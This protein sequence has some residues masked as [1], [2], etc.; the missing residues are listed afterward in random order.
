MME[1]KPTAGSRSGTAMRL[2]HGATWILV[3][4]M[5]RIGSVSGKVRAKQGVEILTLEKAPWCM[6]PAKK[7]DQ[8]SVHYIGKLKNGTV[9]DEGTE[10]VGRPLGFTL[11]QDAASSLTGN[12]IEG[13]HVGLEGMCLHEKRRIVVPPSLAYGDEGMPPSIPGKATLVFDVEL[14]LLNGQ[15]M[16]PLGE[17]EYCDGCLLVVEHFYERWTETMTKQLSQ[18]KQTPGGDKPPAITYN[19]DTEAMVQGFCSSKA[20]R[21]NLV[22]PFV[23][24][25]CEEIMKGWKRDLVGKFLSEHVQP[26][27]VPKK[28]EEVCRDMVGACPSVVDTPP[29][30]DCQRCKV[31]MDSLAFDLRTQGPLRRAKG[32]ARQA[33]DTLDYACMKL[34]YRVPKAGKTQELCEDI[35]DEHGSEIVSSIEKGEP[36]PELRSRVCGTL[37]AL[38]KA[39]QLR[40]EL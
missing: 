28:K 31:A 4:N 10:K 21:N 26:T 12:V 34:H 37:T 6:E 5:I 36:W 25:A 27:M 30:G 20:I 9:F 15:S 24:P 39:N 11:G 18:A 23:G 8:L 33:W 3:L 7:G 17:S 1:G 16:A 38:C 29:S 40:D 2:L 14:V 35:V 13:W 19:E 32:A 22:A